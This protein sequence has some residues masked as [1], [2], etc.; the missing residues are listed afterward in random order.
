MG[1]IM[2]EKQAVTRYHAAAKKLKS[3][4]LDEFTR[5]TGYHRKSAVRF[6]TTEKKRSANRTGKRFYP[7]DVITALRSASRCPSPLNSRRFISR[8]R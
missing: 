6:I 2:K 8:K 3:D 1:L 5:L 7:D 4:L